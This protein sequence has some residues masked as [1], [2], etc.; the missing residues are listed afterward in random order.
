MGHFS[1]EKSLNPGS[2]LSGNQHTGLA[3]RLKDLAALLL[4]RL[5]A[6]IGA[7][8]ELRRRDGAVPLIARTRMQRARP[9][10][11]GAKLATW[12][13][14]LEHYHAALRDLMPRLLVIQF[15]GPIG[16]REDLRGQGDAVA[17]AMASRLMLGSTPPWHA[18]RDRIGTFASWLSLVSGTLG[19]IGQDIVLMTQNE[20]DEIRLGSS[21]GGSSSI[22]HKSNPVQGE[23]LVTLARFNAG[24][25][26]LLHQALVH[27][28]E[29]SGSAW[30]LEWLVL[31]QMAISTAAS[32]RKACALLGGS[33][34]FVAS[35]PDFQRPSEQR[36]KD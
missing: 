1:M 19:K 35:S 15:G 18:Q 20:V 13:A 3:L 36:L 30:T 31:P 2:A 6:V 32:L 23:M 22:P 29:R 26:G 10:T 27:E 25:L 28:N 24:L 34:R 16:T 11:A 8:A 9:F 33:V 14:P 12:I 4:D 17:D 5:D 21:G 7:L